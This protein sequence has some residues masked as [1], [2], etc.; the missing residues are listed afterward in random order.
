MQD[1]LD[2]LELTLADGVLTSAEKRGLLAQLQQRPL[3]P[4]QLR[5]MRNH[6]F[7]LVHAR[8]LQA[9][10]VA[11]LPPLIRWLNQIIKTLDQVQPQVAV[12][13]EV[14]FSP[15]RACLDAV[16]GHL[17]SC[18]QQAD[19]CVFT[20]AD[21]RITDALLA[22]RARGV[23]LRLISDDDKRY[24]RGSDIERLHAAGIPVMVDHSEAHMHHKFA[25]F[26]QRRLLNGSFNWTRSAS[27][28]NEENLVSSSDPQLIA[29]FQAQFDR[30]WQRF[31]PLPG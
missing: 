14:W 29:H 22:A 11:T 10:A 2:Q 27:E 25:L 31:R 6:A 23:A 30:L 1:L 3:R 5:Q 26:D 12:Q 16:V 15:G 4:D 24:D 18:R 20:I 7:D 8:A 28:A 19:V 21:D 9:D 13:T 17:R